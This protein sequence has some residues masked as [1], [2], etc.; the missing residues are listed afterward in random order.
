MTNQNSGIIICEKGHCDTSMR[1]IVNSAGIE[2]LTVFE[3]SRQPRSMSTFRIFKICWNI[4]CY[5]LCSHHIQRSF[6]V[7]Q[8]PNPCATNNGGC[9]H[10]CVLIP[11]A[12]WRSCLCPVGVR[13]LQDRLTCSPSGWF[14]FFFCLIVHFY[15]TLHDYYFAGVERVL[16]VA[17]TSG[18][19]YISLDTMEHAPMPVVYAGSEIHDT[20][21]MHVDYD[22]VEKKVYVI[23][24]DAGVIRRFNFNGTERE[25]SFY[26]YE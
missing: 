25:V 9:S 5:W 1:E 4:V 14:V 17:T 16:F 24:G 6:F 13:L 3:H 12:P 23:D 26:E 7:G 11:G 8:A 15:T 18:L 10:V 20:R 2:A 19:I 22:P 21:I